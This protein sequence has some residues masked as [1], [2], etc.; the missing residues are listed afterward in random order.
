[1]FFFPKVKRYYLRDDNLEE[2]PTIG[3]LYIYIYKDYVYIFLVLSCGA[4]IPQVG[5][6]TQPADSPPVPSA[7][8]LSQ[9]NTM[10]IDAQV[11]SN[12]QN[13]GQLYIYVYDS[14]CIY[15]AVCIST[16]KTISYININWKKNVS[17]AVPSLL[18]RQNID[19]KIDA[20]AEWRR[21]MQPTSKAWCFVA[22]QSKGRMM[23]KTS[24]SPGG[25]WRDWLMYKPTWPGKK[26][27]TWIFSWWTLR[28]L[29]FG[30]IVGFR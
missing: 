12:H 6:Y 16:T 24:P 28:S 18:H 7:G 2:S 20:F 11:H 29:L 30:M 10:D 5:I 15:T 26:N 1:M 3:T 9:E 14:I 8:R 27:A 4:T 13:D 21:V 23:G 22:V 25:R 19:A 17:R